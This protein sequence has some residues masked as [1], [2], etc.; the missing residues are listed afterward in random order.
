M[1]VQVHHHRFA[2]L[3]GTSVLLALLL[4]LAFD[5]A[6]AKAAVQKMFGGGKG[7]GFADTVTKVNSL[8]DGLIPFALPIGGMGLALAGTGYAFGIQQATRWGAGAVGGTALVLAGPGII[9]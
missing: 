8:R 6:A 4:M 7:G 2:Q 5:T 3:V 9:A 1:K